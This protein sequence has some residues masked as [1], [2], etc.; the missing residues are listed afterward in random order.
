MT[1]WIVVKIEN[2]HSAATC[3]AGSTEGI[4]EEEPCKFPWLSFCYL[5]LCFGIFNERDFSQEP[6]PEMSQIIK[7][8]INIFTITAII[9]SF[10]VLYLLYRGEVVNVE[11]KRIFTAAIVISLM[12]QGNSV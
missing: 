11:A 3:Y 2:C 8:T 10:G 4:L 6:R 1:F 12:Q 9:I 7:G 5:F